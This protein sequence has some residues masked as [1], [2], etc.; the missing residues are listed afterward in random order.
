MRDNMK[1][2]LDRVIQ[3]LE[4]SKLKLDDL[5]TSVKPVGI[6]RFLFNTIERSIERAEVLIFEKLKGLV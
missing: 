2:T 3:H 6:D 1:S 5:R 4:Q